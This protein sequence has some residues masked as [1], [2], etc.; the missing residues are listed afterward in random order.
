[1]KKTNLRPATGFT[2][3]ELLVVVVIIATLSAL[4]LIG[5]RRMR[6]AGDRAATLPVMRQLQVANM[7]YASENSGQYVPIAELD[8][9]NQLAMEWYENPKFLVHLTGNS[10]VF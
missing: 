8:R 1:M 4:S 3:V 9:N 7:M 10:T 5:F 6:A 2:L